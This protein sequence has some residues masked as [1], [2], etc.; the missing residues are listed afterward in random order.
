MFT[1]LV[2]GVG[3]VIRMVPRGRE[4]E[5][6][7]KPP[8]PLGEAVVGESIAVSGACL[9]VTRTAGDGLA[10]DVSAETL[11]R[12]I[13]GKLRPGSAVNLERALKLGERLGGHLVTGHVDCVGNIVRMHK[14]G[15]SLSILVAIPPEHLRMVVE[16]GSVAV[17]GVSLTVNEVNAKGFGLNLI[18]HTLSATTLKLAKE[19]DSVNI[20][21]DLIGKYVARLMN[22]EDNQ[23]RGGL[24]REDLIRL[25][26]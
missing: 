17:D 5:L 7:L 9:T 10:A 23:G 14:T 6:W 24:S 1:G 16:K 15:E 11:S 21:T 18:P 3:Q 20:E 4:A 13:L 19:G 22:R 25:G 2:E 8:W 26:F 12:T